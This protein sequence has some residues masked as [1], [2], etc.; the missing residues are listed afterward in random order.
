MLLIVDAYASTAD[1]AAI[2]AT[3][4]K[5]VCHLGVPVQD[6]GDEQADDDETVPVFGSGALHHGRDVVRHRL[7]LVDDDPGLQLHVE[8]RGA[9][10]CRRGAV[11][12]AAE[13]LH[14]LQGHARALGLQRRWGGRCGRTENRGSGSGVGI[15]MA[16]EV[17]DVVKE[18]D[19]V[20]RAGARR[21][22]ARHARIRCLGR[23]EDVLVRLYR[24]R[25]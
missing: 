19:A 12:A 15:G 13:L 8:G 2:A 20:G 22:H 11:L 5:R 14:E 1:L 4:A 18:V 10:D 23:V 17:V 6:L 7:A 21:G 9:E 16:L 25:E 24:R 3:A